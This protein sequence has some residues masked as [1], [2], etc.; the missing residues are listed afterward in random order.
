MAELNTIFSDSDYSA[1]V[2]VDDLTWMESLE[3]LCEG[4]PMLTVP[5]EYDEHDTFVRIL[6]V[7]DLCLSDLMHD[8]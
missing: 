8:G 6:S 5:G 3:I 7:P 4:K 2:Q 1:D